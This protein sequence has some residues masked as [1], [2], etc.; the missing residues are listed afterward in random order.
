M[1]MVQELEEEMRYG[2]ERR[3]T[4]R[5]GNGTTPGRC[6]PPRAEH[7]AEAPRPAWEEAQAHETKD[8]ATRRREFTGLTFGLYAKGVEK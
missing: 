2:Q 5:Q 8:A 6:N 1:I 3:Q 4:Q 7:P